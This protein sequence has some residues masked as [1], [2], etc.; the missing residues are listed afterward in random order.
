MTRD[1]TVN[2]GFQYHWDIATIFFEVRAILKRY[3]WL[4]QSKKF[5]DHC[6]AIHAFANKYVQT[7]IT[8]KRT[9]DKFTAATNPA[10]K[11]IVLDKLVKIITDSIQLRHEC[12]NI[13][14][15]S[16]TG[17]VFLIQ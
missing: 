4:Y 1:L 17:I 14:G 12:L 15:A 9:R 10:E 6:S 5:R 8:R 13:L 11:I 7:V 16:R 2:K 3:C